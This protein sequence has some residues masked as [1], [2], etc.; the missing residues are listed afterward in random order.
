M[1]GRKSGQV[2]SRYE[3]FRID[4]SSNPCRVPHAHSIVFRSPPHQ[5]TG[6]SEAWPEA[7]YH[8][9][10]IDIAADMTA[11]ISLT[12]MVRF[13]KNYHFFNNIDKNE[14][15]FM[16]IVSL[17][18]II[19][20]FAVQIAGC[21]YSDERVHVNIE[22]ALARPDSHVF[23]VAVHYMRV[24]HPTGFLNTFPDGGTW[25]V[26]KR[27]ARIYIV[28][29]DSQAITLAAEID[30]FGGI[31]KPKQVWIQGWQGSDVYFS[32]LGYGGDVRAGDHPSDKQRL[33]YR[34]SAQGQIHRIDSLPKNL[35]SARNS[36]PMGEPPF[37]RLSKG[38]NV[39]HVGVNG[40]PY[41]EERTARFW[42]DEKTGEPHFSSANKKDGQ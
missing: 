7:G 19:I 14:N 2:K 29:A 31:P 32:L 22:N 41:R 25:R 17:T 9:A 5:D 21:S 30:E 1:S 18:I 13:K 34:V 12:Q 36:G 37:L 42:L 40:A 26:L 20:P 38:H 28:D 23:A 3:G 11:C 39:V 15:F 8:K 24:Q 6:I 35:T 27:K 10:Y 4:A 33:N 16:K